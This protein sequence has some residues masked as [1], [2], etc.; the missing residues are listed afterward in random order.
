M[1]EGS[2]WH[3]E[4]FRAKN[5]KT[6]FPTARRTFGGKIRPP[7][8]FL[9]KIAELFYS[10]RFG[11]PDLQG[12]EIAK[13]MVSRPFWP[14]AALGTSGPKTE[15]HNFL[16]LGRRL[17]GKSIRPKSF[18][19]KLRNFFTVCVLADRTPGGGKSQNTVFLGPFGLGQPLAL[20]EIPGQKG[21]NTISWS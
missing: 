5:G 13:Y 8:K 6:Q 12:R 10:L 20:G 15:K 9:P 3:L 17:G 2:P 4:K 19:Q 7:Q 14:R 16:E 1:A 11:Q 18:S 21:K